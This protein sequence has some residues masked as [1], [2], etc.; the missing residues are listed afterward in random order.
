MGVNVPSVILL[1]IILLIVMAPFSAEQCSTQKRTG[2]P[3]LVAM[4]LL[5]YFHNF[6]LFSNLILMTSILTITL[7]IAGKTSA[8]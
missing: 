7:L 5:I 2:V 8:L 4:T 6:F 1:F 3:Q